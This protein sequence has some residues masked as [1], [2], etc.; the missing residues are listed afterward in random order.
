MNGRQQ[1]MIE[2]ALILSRFAFKYDCEESARFVRDHGAEAFL[3]KYTKR[4]MALRWEQ[5]EWSTSNK[6]EHHGGSR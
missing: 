4:G 2:T 3:C 1:K 6:I 5:R